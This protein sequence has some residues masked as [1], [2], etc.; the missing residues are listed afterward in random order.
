MRTVILT[1]DRKHSMMSRKEA[2]EIEKIFGVYLDFNIDT[3]VWEIALVESGNRHR[4]KP[5]S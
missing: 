3:Q 5:T 2:A 1:L 4:S